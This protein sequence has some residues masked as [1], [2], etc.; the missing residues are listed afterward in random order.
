MTATAN[1]LKI[2]GTCWNTTLSILIRRIKIFLYA[3]ISEIPL[4]HAKLYSLFYLQ[5]FPISLLWQQRSVVLD[6]H[7]HYSFARCH[8][9]KGR[10]HTSFKDTDK[11]RRPHKPL[12]R[13]YFTEIEL[14]Q[15]YVLVAKEKMFCL[16]FTMALNLKMFSVL[17]HLCTVYDFIT[18]FCTK[19]IIITFWQ[20]SWILTFPKSLKFATIFKINLHINGHILKISCFYP[21]NERFCVFGI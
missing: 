13:L 15:I 17:R 10:L 9:N 20:P 14:Q 6:F 11:I 4:T 18:N 2:Y 19:L 16:K 7:W 8:G 5:I 1:L 12:L 3:K 21:Q